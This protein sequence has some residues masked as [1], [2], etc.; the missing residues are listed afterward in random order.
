[1]LPP[2]VLSE[3][4][5]PPPLTLPLMELGL[6]VPSTGRSQFTL[7]PD[8]LA[9][10]SALKS[11]GTVKLMLPPDVVNSSGCS[12]WPASSALMEH[13]AIFRRTIPGL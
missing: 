11:L 5:G 4:F 6:T 9:V 2:E 1:M 10:R 8:V 12:I 7:P 3:T 13:H